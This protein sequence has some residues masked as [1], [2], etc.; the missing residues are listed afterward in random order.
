M[1]GSAAMPRLRGFVSTVRRRIS[2]ASGSQ[3]LEHDFDPD[4]SVSNWR[5]ASEQFIADEAA[6]LLARYHLRKL[7]QWYHSQAKTWGNNVSR[8]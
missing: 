2:A 5:R 1:M 8:H 6:R 3:V 4:V 7:P